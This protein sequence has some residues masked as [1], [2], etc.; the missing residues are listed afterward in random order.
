MAHSATYPEGVLSPLYKVLTETGNRVWKASGTQGTTLSILVKNTKM[1]RCSP[2]HEKLALNP[3]DAHQKWNKYVW[4]SLIQTPR[5]S[6]SFDFAYEMDL[7]QIKAITG[8]TWIKGT[9]DSSHTYSDAAAARKAAVRSSLS[10]EDW[11][12]ER[13]P[14]ISFFMVILVS[15][16]C[17]RAHGVR[18]YVIR[19]TAW[20]SLLARCPNNR[21]MLHVRLYQLS[22]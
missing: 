5:V 11:S 10:I 17:L 16:N 3:F 4:K 8:I 22:Y 20:R 19:S 2:R 13:N 12:T 15:G 6:K 21:S 9:F 18:T 14:C 1:Q 7:T